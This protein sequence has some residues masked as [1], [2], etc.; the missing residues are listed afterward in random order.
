MRYDFIIKTNYSKV[1]YSDIL[2][3]DMLSLG[4]L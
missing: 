4:S 1:Y 2:S 3:A